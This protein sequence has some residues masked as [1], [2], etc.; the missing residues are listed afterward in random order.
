MLPVE[1]RCSV[2]GK[3]GFYNFTEGKTLEA[4]L[5]TSV[6]VSGEDSAAGLSLPHLDELL[7]EPCIGS[8]HASNVVMTLVLAL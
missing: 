8:I 7:V 5:T 6:C 2:C 1:L 3:Q 4:V